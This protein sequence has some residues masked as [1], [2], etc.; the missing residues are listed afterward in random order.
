MLKCNRGALISRDIYA[1]LEAQ[2]QSIIGAGRVA[3]GGY[4]LVWVLC[5]LSETGCFKF[6]LRNDLYMIEPI[7]TCTAQTELAVADS[8]N[9]GGICLFVYV[10][11][12]DVTCHAV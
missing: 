4:E 3:A 7:V 11:G 1:A 6:Q 12:C 5:R 2:A 10:D 8:G 9:F